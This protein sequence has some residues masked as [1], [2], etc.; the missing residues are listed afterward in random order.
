MATY[1]YVTW[2]PDDEVTSTK[3]AQMANNE[4][5]I[6]DNMLTGSVSYRAGGDGVAPTGKT[7]GTHVADTVYGIYQNFNSLVATTSYTIKIT[8]PPIFTE[9]PVI[10]ATVANGNAASSFVCIITRNS[11]TDYA[12]VRIFRRDGA[13]VVISG[14][15]NVMLIGK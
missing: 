11:G 7:P 8:Y 4:Q 2:Q 6:H 12:N 15:L 10:V 13:A 1:E 5:W 3:L 14:G 9:P